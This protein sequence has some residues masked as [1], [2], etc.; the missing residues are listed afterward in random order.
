[1]KKNKEAGTSKKDF[2]TS[3]INLEEHPKT[4]NFNREFKRLKNKIKY[5]E[6]KCAHDGFLTSEEFLEIARKFQHLM[7]KASGSNHNGDDQK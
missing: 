2:S 4:F 3:D 5:L 7:M 1:M 6:S